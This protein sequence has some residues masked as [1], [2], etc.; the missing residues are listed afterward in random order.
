MENKISWKKPNYKNE[1]KRVS[2][3]EIDKMCIE[4]TSSGDIKIEKDKYGR[5]IKF[6]V[7]R[8][9]K[10]GELIEGIDTLTR[11]RAIQELKRLVKGKL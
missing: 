4:G 3:K 7:Y 10:V 11:E 6:Y 8:I 5:K 1:F 2:A 9:E